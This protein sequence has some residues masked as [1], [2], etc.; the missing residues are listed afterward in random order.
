MW[1]YRPDDLLQGDLLVLVAFWGYTT[2]E[3]KKLLCH[4]MHIDLIVIPEIMINQLQILDIAVNKWFK[5]NLLC[6][7]NK[8]LPMGNH[9]LTPTDRIKKIHQLLNLAVGKSA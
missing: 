9:A 5:Y 1:N 7:Y 4:E 8:W 6:L 3:V 2:S